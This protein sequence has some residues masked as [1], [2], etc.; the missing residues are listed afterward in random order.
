MS[1]VPRSSPPDRP[2]SRAT[3]AGSLALPLQLA[4]RNLF[5]NTR[6]T[7][8]TAL[9]LAIGTAVIV[10]ARGLVNGLNDGIVLGVTETRLGDVQLHHAAYLESAEA[11]PLDKTFPLDARVDEL[12]RA[13]PRIQQV[14][15]R[16]HFS[17]LASYGEQTT[18]FFGLG[19]DA[20]GEYAI[21]PYQKNNLIEGQILASSQPEQVVIGRP[22]ADALGVGLGDSLTLV[23]TTQTGALNGLD[24]TIR[25]IIE[26]KL[27][28]PGSRV[29]QLPLESAQKLL[30]MPGQ[31]SEAILNIAPLEDAVSVTEGLSARLARSTAEPP[32]VAH[33]WTTLGPQFLHMM[34]EQEYV[35]QYIIVTLYVTMISGIV[36]TMLMSVFERTQEIG[37]MMALG[38]TRR[39]ILSLFLIESL[40]LGFLGAVVGSGC[41]AGVVVFFQWIGFPLPPVGQATRWFA[42]YPRIDAAYLAQVV[43]IAMSCALGAALYPAWRASRMNPAEALH[44]PLG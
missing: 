32:L 14:S 31:V 2:P 4:L 40:L 16:I 30:R 41:G 37:T 26:Y 15:G 6:R 18:L 23:V 24:V 29:I 11:L 43:G 28:G 13:D 10:F 36:N 39:R 20:V 9:G 38:V 5:R 25:G 35:L 12:L 34:E 44:A 17:G 3:D 8:I 19:M 1:P 7:L 21:C 42:I 27:P 33:A 22:L